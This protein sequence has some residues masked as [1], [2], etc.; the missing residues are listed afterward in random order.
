MQPKIQNNEE[1]LPRLHKPE[2]VAQVLSFNTEC[3]RRALREGRIHGV[4]AG[5]NWRV[6]DEELLRIC[7]EG[8]SA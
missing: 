7:K 1:R 3:V 4:K 2:A 6:T 5:R 8:I